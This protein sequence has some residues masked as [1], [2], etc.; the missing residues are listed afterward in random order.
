MAG[1]TRSR[2]PESTR[3]FASMMRKRWKTT[4]DWSVRLPP[5]DYT[6]DQRMRDMVMEVEEPLFQW[7]SDVVTLTLHRTNPR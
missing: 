7:T 5:A 3:E 2:R 6:E 4:L 1:Y